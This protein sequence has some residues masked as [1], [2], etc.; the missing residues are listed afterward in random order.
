MRHSL[1]VLA[2][3]TIVALAT[4]ELPA[5]AEAAPDATPAPIAWG[6]CP[7]S[8]SGLGD[9]RFQCATLAVP[10]DYRAPAGAKSDIAI[11]RLQTAAPALYLR[12]RDDFVGP[13]VHRQH[14]LVGS[15]RRHRA[16]EQILRGQ[17][18]DCLFAGRRWFGRSA[19]NTRRRLDAAVCVATIRG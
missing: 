19:C 9:P 1:F 2:G 8:S 6:P 14:A 12:H 4:P 16:L 5:R 13:F 3:L 18:I 7:A 10:L 15:D 11:S 17:R